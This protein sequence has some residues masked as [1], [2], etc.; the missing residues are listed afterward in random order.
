MPDLL[1][2]STLLSSLI[3]VS[4]GA[5]M[6]SDMNG[7]V[8]ANALEGFSASVED[9][10]KVDEQKI[11]QSAF[12][13]ETNTLT[14]DERV[15]KEKDMSDKKVKRT[16]ERIGSSS[17]RKSDIL[18]IVQSKGHATVSDIKEF[19]KDISDKTIQRDL[20]TLVL[21]GQIRKEGDRR[22]AKYFAR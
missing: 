7:S 15:V 13:L 19:I 10:I 21:E 3:R 16:P 6:I 1:E 4:R 11:H 14:K 22:W 12:L 9:M 20:S 5:N 18:A 8:L 2:K 17:D